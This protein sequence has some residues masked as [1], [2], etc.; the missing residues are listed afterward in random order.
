MPSLSTIP[1]DLAGANRFSIQVIATVGSSIANLEVS[2]NSTN[3]T[4][5]DSFSLS[6]GQTNIF[7]RTSC[8]YRYARVTIENNDVISVSAR[9]LVLAIG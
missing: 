6:S 8:D 5:I 1:I 9:C 7:V 4:Q 2:S 3:W